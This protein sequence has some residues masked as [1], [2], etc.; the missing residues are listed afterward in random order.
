MQGLHIDFIGLRKYGYIFSITLT[1]LSVVV[2]STKGLSKG[3]DFTGGRTYIVKFEKPVN[4]EEIANLLSDELG[5]DPMVVTFGS[6]NQVKIST[7]FKVEDPAATDEV[8]GLIYTGLKDLVPGVD[9]A[10]FINDYI[11]SSETVGPTIARDQAGKAVWAIILALIGMFTIHFYQ[12]PQVAVWGRFISNSGTRRY[13]CAWSLHDPAGCNAI[14]NGYRPGL[15][16]C[17]FDRRRI[18]DQ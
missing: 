12:V 8:N 16:S 11:I 14:L 7:K 13:N 4:T 5:G 2:L 17:N 15:H 3:I 10:T 1:L 18:L 6:E 9:Q